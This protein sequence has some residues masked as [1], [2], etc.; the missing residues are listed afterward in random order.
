MVLSAVELNLLAAKL[1]ELVGGATLVNLKSVARDGAEYKTTE[2]PV[3]NETLTFAEH[4][5]VLTMTVGGQTQM[6]SFG[7]RG[8]MVVVKE[9]LPLL[10]GAVTGA[11]NRISRAAQVPLVEM[12]PASEATLPPVL[13]ELAMSDGTR[14]LLCDANRLGGLRPVDLSKL[15]R[16]VVQYTDPAELAAVIQQA[17]DGNHRQSLFRLLMERL[18]GLDALLFCEA[19]HAARMSPY[20]TGGDILRGPECVGLLA[21]ALVEVVQGR[22]RGRETQ[23]FESISAE[24]DQGPGVGSAKVFYFQRKN[25]LYQSTEEAIHAVGPRKAKARKADG[26]E[27]K[28]AKEGEEGKVGESAAPKARKR[29]PPAADGAPKQPRKRATPTAADGDADGEPK[30]PKPAKARK[31]KPADGDA[32]AKPAKPRAPRKPKPTKPADDAAAPAPAA[33]TPAAPVVDAFADV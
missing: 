22:L 12:A 29:A 28:E 15:A 31:P 6:V 32:A 2:T 8:F 27:G 23:V 4:G 30:E 9:G 10:T 3:A 5:K 7:M 16:S 18:G 19:A 33:A 13:L 20:M 11:G 21:G 25:W 1:A 26:E 17:A 24:V 14:V